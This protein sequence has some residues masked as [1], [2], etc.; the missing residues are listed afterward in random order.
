MPTRDAYSHNGRAHNEQ[1]E[2]S[3]TSEPIRDPLSDG[4]FFDRWCHASSTGAATTAVARTQA[5][6]PA[7]AAREARSRRSSGTTVAA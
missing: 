6:R 2:Q 7:N 5:A 3:M 4:A 1:R